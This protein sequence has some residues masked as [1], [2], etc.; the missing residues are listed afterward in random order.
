MALPSFRPDD[1]VGADFREAVSEAISAFLAEKGQHLQGI[2]QEL[3]PLHRLATEFTAGGKRF[4]PALC[5]WGYTA[6]AEQPEDAAWLVRAAA[7]LDLLHVSALVHDDVMDA[8]D[9]RRGVPAVHRQLQQWH[10]REHGRGGAE[11]FGRAGAILLGDLLLVWSAEMFDRSGL[12][13]STRERATRLLEQ[14]RE[15]VTCGQFLDVVSQTQLFADQDALNPDNLAA[16]LDRIYRVVDYKSARYSAR[17]PLEIG[18]ALA[19]AED[20][21]RVRLGDFG[22]LIGRAFQFRDDL[23]G[24]FGDE[25]KTGKPAGDDLREGKRTVL[26]AHALAAAPREQARELDAML[27]NPHLEAAQIDRAREIIMGVGAHEAVEGEI[28]SSVAQA[29][30]VLAETPVTT[31]GREALEL[32]AA[33][34]VDRQA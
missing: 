18:A 9:T 11:A 33:I 19:G 28:A 20:S 21:T 3:E 26:V 25:D 5:Y 14:M 8:S 6:I 7:S 13:T 27:G 31:E 22:S 29:L 15:E 4:R 1:P 34:V 12:P 16:E 17:H 30:S 23:L 10:E 2:G 32:L 24:V